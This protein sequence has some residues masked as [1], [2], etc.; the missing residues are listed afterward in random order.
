MPGPTPAPPLRVLDLTD[1]L[2][3]QGAR[4]LV[5]IG[6]DVVRVDPDEDLEPAERVHWHA[7]KRWVRLPDERV[8]D[9]L[10]AGADVVLES[11]P[12]AAL[13]G[14]RADG[15]SRWP[16]AP[17]ARRSRR[18]GS[19]RS[20]SPARTRPSPRC[21]ACWPGTGPDRVSSSTSRARR[22]WRPPSRPPRSPGSTPAG[23][24][25]ATAV[26]TSTSRT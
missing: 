4:L 10:A 7:G 18:R 8:L 2:A 6:A 1:R 17:T 9:T 25:S 20:S 24:R 16:H 14:V 3:H 21:S 12:V 5:G 23:S 26:S 15:T 22:P 11:G 19:R 13:R